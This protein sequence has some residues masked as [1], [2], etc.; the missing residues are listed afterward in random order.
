MDER[1][2]HPCRE[3]TNYHQNSQAINQLNR[4]RRQSAPSSSMLQEH[5][6]LFMSQE[7]RAS[8]DIVDRTDDIR[9]YVSMYYPR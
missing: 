3:A 4:H 9:F 8:D 2:Q 6:T 1:L 7:H 5:H